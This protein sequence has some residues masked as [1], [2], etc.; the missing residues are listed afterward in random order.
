[1]EELEQTL[2]SRAALRSVQSNSARGGD[3]GRDDGT[4][5]MKGHGGHGGHGGTGK[6]HMSETLSEPYGM[7][8]IKFFARSSFNII[9]PFNYSNTITVNL[10]HTRLMKLKKV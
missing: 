5:D 2:A 6:E 4:L 3:G 10:S 8:R 1:M 7:S 9:H